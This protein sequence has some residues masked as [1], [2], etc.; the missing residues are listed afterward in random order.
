MWRSVRVVKGDGIGA[1]LKGIHAARALLLGSW[2]CARGGASRALERWI[3]RTGGWL[4]AWY[5]KRAAV[6][7]APE[8]QRERLEAR[9]LKGGLDEG[10]HLRLRLRGACYCGVRP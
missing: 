10:E 8:L 2:P 9:L 1:T 7:F 3:G 6:L 4:R 5:S